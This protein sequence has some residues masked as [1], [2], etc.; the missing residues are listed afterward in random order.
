MKGLIL[1][2]LYL[3]KRYAR[4]YTLYLLVFG[5]VGAY[6]G[7][8]SFFVSMTSVILLT[9]PLSAWNY[10]QYNKWDRAAL[11]GPVSRRQLVQAK[12]LLTLLLMTTILVLNFLVQ[13]GDD[14]ISSPVGSRRT[15]DNYIVRVLP[16]GFVSFLSFPFIIRFGV[17]KGRMVMILSCLLVAGI[18]VLGFGGLS[19]ANGGLSNIPDSTF[20]FWL[21]AVGLPLLA[22]LAAISYFLSLRFYE[23]REVC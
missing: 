12:Y 7:M 3:W 17:E 6:S 4:I 5:A 19:A 10:D 23:A 15:V 1:K 20:L 13:S 22:L 21:F 2:D 18:L 16:V 8:A 11:A 14:G 9:L